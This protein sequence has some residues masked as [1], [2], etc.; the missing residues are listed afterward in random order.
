MEI[1]YTLTICL[2]QKNFFWISKL[3]K[4]FVDV[5]AAEIE[6]EYLLPLYTTK[7]IFVSFLLYL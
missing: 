2:L 5:G 4:K 1:F 7:Q 3:S 6:P